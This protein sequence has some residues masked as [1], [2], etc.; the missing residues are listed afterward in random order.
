MPHFQGRPMSFPEKLSFQVR[1]RDPLLESAIFSQLRGLKR[2]SF[3]PF[4]CS[5]VNI[6]RWQHLDAANQPDGEP[7]M[8]IL[9]SPQFTIVTIVKVL[10]LVPLQCH[11]PWTMMDHGGEIPKHPQ[12]KWSLK[13]ENHRTRSLSG[14][15]WLAMAAMQPEPEIQSRRLLTPAPLECGS[16]IEFY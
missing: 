7:L 3:E 5:M 8:V 1:I 14:H 10:G 13:W 15:V 6:V 9:W 11:Q 16:T 2:W 12:T 4:Y